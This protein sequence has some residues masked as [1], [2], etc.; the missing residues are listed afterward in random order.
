ME[1]KDYKF[2]AKSIEDSRYHPA[3]GSWVIGCFYYDNEN[4]YIRH[5]YKIDKNGRPT[6]YM[7]TRVDPDTL[8]QY[9]GMKD[10]NGVEIYEYDLLSCEDYTKLRLFCNM[11][12][13]GPDDTVVFL[14]LSSATSVQNAEVYGNV[15]DDRYIR[16][17]R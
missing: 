9:T 7:S 2:K 11:C 5:P 17:P 10:K 8:C 14:R 1:I 3:K 13:P 6:S 16:A 4:A 12:L 15:F